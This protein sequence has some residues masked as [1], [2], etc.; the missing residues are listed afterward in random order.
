VSAGAL[1]GAA[2]YCVD[3]ESASGFSGIVPGP[4]VSVQLNATIFFG[5]KPLSALFAAKPVPKETHTAH[6]LF[7]DR[8][9]PV[10]LEAFFYQ[11]SFAW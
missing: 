4:G 2:N 3:V 9:L 7:L 11:T 6:T 10:R 5:D 1:G 8:M